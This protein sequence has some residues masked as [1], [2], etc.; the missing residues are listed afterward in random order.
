M[1]SKTIPCQRRRDD[2]TLCSAL[3]LVRSVEHSYGTRMSWEVGGQFEQ[4]VTETRYAIE[5]PQCGERVKI[6]PAK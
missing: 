2:G 4:F 1:T 3:A 5:C 6:E